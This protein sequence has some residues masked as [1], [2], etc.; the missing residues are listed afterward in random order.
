MYDQL[1]APKAEYW[2]R[3]ETLSG[4]PTIHFADYPELASFDCPDNSHIDATDALEFTRRLI[5]I[6]KSKLGIEQAPP[7][8]SKE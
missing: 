1:R 5:P 3:I 4:I 6:V 7:S 8:P 2:D